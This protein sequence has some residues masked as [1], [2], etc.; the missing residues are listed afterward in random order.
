MA[1]FKS[2]LAKSAGKF[3]GIFNQT[4]LSLRGADQTSR[5]IEPPF[6][7]TGGTTVEPGNGYKYH[8]FSSSGSFEAT[9]GAEI[10]EIFLVGGGGGA[11]DSL[12][13]GGGA[14]G[15][16]YLQNQ[17]IPK[18]TYTITIG[19]GGAATDAGAPS[20]TL[21]NPGT[22]T[23]F[24]A[25]PSSTLTALGGG[26]GGAY[27]GANAGPGGSG[28]GSGANTAGIG[29]ALQPS[30][31]QPFAS[32][33]ATLNQYGNPGNPLNNSGNIGGGGGGAG[34]GGVPASAPGGNGQPFSGFAA[35]IISPAIPA[36]L[37]PTFIS[38]VGPTGLYGGGGGA[39]ARDGYTAGQG[40]PGGG[41]DGYNAS[42]Q[43]PQDGT[44]HTGGGGG[45]GSYPYTTEENGAGGS[46]IAII[47]YLV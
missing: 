7:A 41:G 22:A 40:G 29:T 10:C 35:P 3:L 1:P 19:G 46:G 30:Q 11:S 24:S 4:D 15:V 27:S 18:G 6:S 2:S 47:R 34:S 38:A 8:V 28:G 21:G 20:S 39:G 45:S 31:P 25:S 42:P 36:P 12:A 33:T 23:T 14:G 32:P 37:Q 44:S 16:V 26:R 17:Y 13:G 9:G 43:G 5:F